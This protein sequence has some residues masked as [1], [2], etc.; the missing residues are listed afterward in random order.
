MCHVRRAKHKPPLLKLRFN[1]SAHPNSRYLPNPT[2]DYRWTLLHADDFRR[3]V[4]GPIT[5][6]GVVSCCVENQPSLMP[7]KPCCFKFIHRFNRKWFYTSYTFY[8]PKTKS[9]SKASFEVG[10]AVKQCC[11]WIHT[12][13][14]LEKYKLSVS[15]NFVHVLP[16]RSTRLCLVAAT[17]AFLYAFE[18]DDM[19]KAF[20]FPRV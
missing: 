18:S 7:L 3:N 17:A 9:L 4:V 8:V 6:S 14:T 11:V 19:F 1:W 15:L 5:C 13:R 20:E 16:H 2:Q 10:S 12:R